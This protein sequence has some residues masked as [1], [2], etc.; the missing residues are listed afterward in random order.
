MQHNNFQSK[1]QENANRTHFIE[2]DNIQDFLSKQHNTDIPSLDSGY[3]CQLNLKAIKSL[4]Y[5]MNEL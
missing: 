5:A 1:Q 2:N 4:N 3:Q